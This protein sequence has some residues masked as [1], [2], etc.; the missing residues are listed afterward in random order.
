MEQSGPA[1]GR[2][3]AVA[4]EWGGGGEEVEGEEEEGGRAAALAGS[5]PGSPT[6]FVVL[7]VVQSCEYPLG[8]GTGVVGVVVKGVV[9]KDRQIHVC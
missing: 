7:L 5:D 8:S 3:E 2:A 1:V 9:R 6:G 4:G